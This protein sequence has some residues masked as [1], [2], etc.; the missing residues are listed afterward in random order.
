MSRGAPFV[1]ACPSCD[2]PKITARETKT[3]TYRCNVCR[4]RFESPTRRQNKNHTYATR[5]DSVD[6]E[7][8]QTL[9]AALQ[10]TRD[11]GSSHAR[12]KL[13]AQYSDVL[14]TQEAA[15]LLS[16]WAE[17]RGD[18]E[19]YREASLGIIWRITVDDD[20]APEVPA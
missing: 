5:D 18:V 8:Y 13:I 19:R 12:A 1:D 2:S 17:P 9:L 11:A 3:P 7:R 10:R 20:A 15:R 16:R 4:E 14:D 6:S